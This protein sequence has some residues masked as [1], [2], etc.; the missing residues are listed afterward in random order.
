MRAILLVTAVAG[1]CSFAPAATK[2]SNGEP[3]DAA[4]DAQSDG[5]KTDSAPCVSYSKLFDTCAVNR[6][7]TSDLAVAENATYNTDQHTLVLSSG[8]TLYPAHKVVTTGTGEMDVLAVGAFSLATT[9]TLRVQGSIPFGIAATGDVQIDGTI[10]ASQ[11]GSGVRSGAVCGTAKG[12][13]GCG[14]K[15]ACGGGG[16]GFHGVGGAGRSS[17]NSEGSSSVLGGAG[18]SSS[19][20]PAALLGGCSGGNGGSGAGAVGGIGGA[21]GGAVAIATAKA[22]H[23]KGAVNVG[24]AGGS[25]GQFGADGNAGGGGGGGSGGMIVVECKSLTL[26]GAIVANGGGGGEGASEPSNGNPPTNGNPGEAGRAAAT[27][28][29]GGDGNGNS[30]NGGAGGAGLANGGVLAAGPDKGGGGGGGGGTGY[31]AIACGPVPSTG[32][33]SPASAPWP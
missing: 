25:G 33:I 21:G 9:A 17:G 31:I 22:L 1:G 12:S 10:D 27:R 26:T 5:P 16:G 8:T 29:S 18:G 13:N 14:A 20:R 19:G 28:A 4:V 7:G 3:L 2:D 11:G 23:V 32:I 15:L 30:G 6:A 24:G